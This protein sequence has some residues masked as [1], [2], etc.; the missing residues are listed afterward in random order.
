MKT[1]GQ[2]QHMIL[3]LCYLVQNGAYIYENINDQLIAGIEKFKTIVDITNPCPRAY[4][5]QL[6]LTEVT[7]DLAT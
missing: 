4:I 5:E 7:V 1:P 2:P 6:A 3:T